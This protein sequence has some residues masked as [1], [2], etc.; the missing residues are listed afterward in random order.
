MSKYVAFVVTYA[1]YTATVLVFVLHH[2]DCHATHQIFFLRAFFTLV[3]GWAGVGG[4]SNNV[5]ATTLLMIDVHERAYWLLR[6][7]LLMVHQLSLLLLR[8]L[9]FMYVN[10]ITCLLL[11]CALFVLHELSLSLLRFLDFMY[12]N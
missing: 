5:F 4:M 11:R 8:F 7:A 6:C 12:V 3:L 1:R 2:D 10:D 9:D